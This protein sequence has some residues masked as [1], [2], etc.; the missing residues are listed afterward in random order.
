MKALEVKD[1]MAGYVD[2]QMILQGV[3][4]EV[5]MGEF[6]GIVGPN[7]S[8]KTTL[9]RALCGLLPVKHG[10]IKMNEENILN[11][12]HNELAKKVAL[13]PQLMEPVSGFTVREMVM[14]GRTPYMRRFSFEGD[15][16]R[17]VVKWALEEVKIEDLAEIPVNNL[18]GGEF[19]RVAIARALAQEPKILLLDEPISHLD[20]RY[21]VKILRLLRKLRKQRTIIATF[22]DLNMA[23]R[24]CKRMILVHKGMLVAMGTPE[25]VLTAANIWKTYRVKAEVQ[26]NIRNKNSRLVLLP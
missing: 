8:G 6:I 21:Q 2:E 14:L 9:L 13:V 5:N 20:I 12:E 17:E 11:L 19:Q 16:D 1:V 26:K 25:E 24:F 18:S 15:E 3:N 22:H 7:G 4:F 23:A 10:F